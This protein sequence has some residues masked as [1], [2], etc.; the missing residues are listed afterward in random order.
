MAK[1]LTQIQKQ[2]ARLQ[3]QA[4]GL[5]SRESKGVIARIK[6]AVAHYGLTK[7][8]IFDAG[9]ATQDGSMKVRRRKASSGKKA[10]LPPKY[11]NESGQTWSGHGKRPNWF[12]NALAAGKSTEEMLA[13]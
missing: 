11:R 4:D 12:K 6:E 1:S 13:P 5:K 3:Q 10:P 9:K 7:A 2:I 8:D